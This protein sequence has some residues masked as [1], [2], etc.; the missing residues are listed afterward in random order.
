MT[1]HEVTTREGGRSNT[2][3]DWNFVGSQDIANN[4]MSVTFIYPPVGTGRFMEQVSAEGLPRNASGDKIPHDTIGNVY[5]GFDNYVLSS[6]RVT[7][8]AEWSEGDITEAQVD[9]YVA[10]L[11]GANFGNDIE[12]LTR[13]DTTLSWDFVPKD[14]TGGDYSLVRYQPNSQFKVTIASDD[15]RMCCFLRSQNEGHLWNAGSYSIRGG[16]S[17]TINKSG[18][19]CYLSF[20]GDTFSIGGTA[21]DDMAVKNLTSDSVT[22]DNTGTETRKIGVIWRN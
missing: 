18:S 10:W 15:T 11:Q 13:T 16:E 5:V 8:S 7:Y 14:E 20:V 6:G 2:L 1:A 21:V 3:T 19:E 4:D 12:N 9:D 17:L 22:V